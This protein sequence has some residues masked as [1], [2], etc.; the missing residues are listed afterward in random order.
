MNSRYRQIFL[1]TLVG[2][3]CCALGWSS[4]PSEGTTR[5]KPAEPQQ[6]YVGVFRSPSKWYRVTN[7][8]RLK[9]ATCGFLPFRYGFQ[10][11]G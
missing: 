1:P 2:K 8:S 7:E 3:I 11:Q 6:L 5:T 9:T 4:Q 10:L